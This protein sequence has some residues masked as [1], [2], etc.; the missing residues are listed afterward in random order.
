MKPRT[1]SLKARQAV[2][3][4]RECLNVRTVASKLGVK[5]ATVRR[6]LRANPLPI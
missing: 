3:L 5:A 4:Y 2:W 6:W 1:P